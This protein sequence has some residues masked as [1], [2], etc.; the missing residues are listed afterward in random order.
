MMKKTPQELAASRK[1]NLKNKEL[2]NKKSLETSK[3]NPEKKKET[4]RK[5]REKK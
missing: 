2:I 5:Y 4:Q 3:A 1:Y